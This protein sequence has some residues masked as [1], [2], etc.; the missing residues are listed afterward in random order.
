MKNLGDSVTTH[1]VVAGSGFVVASGDEPIE[2]V[3]GIRGENG[4]P[5]REMFTLELDAYAGG[6]SGGDVDVVSHMT[7]Y[8]AG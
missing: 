6:E 7:Y 3:V 2:L 4:S 8:R 1:D 5:S